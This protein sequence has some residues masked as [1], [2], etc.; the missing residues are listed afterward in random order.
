LFAGVILISCAVTGFVATLGAA[1]LW[2]AAAVARVYAVADPYRY[3]YADSPV[4][5]AAAASPLAG[6]FTDEVLYWTPLIQAW[7]TVYQI[8]PNLIATLIQIESCGDPAVSSPAGAQ[9]LFQVMPF[10]FDPG[11]D[12]LDVSTNA[13]RGME[14][15]AGSLEIADGHAGLALAGYNGGHGVIHRGW[16]SWAAETRRYYYW[17]ARIYAEAVAGLAS[18]STLDEWLA[19]GGSHLCVQARQT[20]SELEAAQ[21]VQVIVVPAN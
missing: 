20:Q 13:R 9:G 18:S 2:N 3:G 17:G 4:G 5:P 16:A 15:L 8:D 21:R 1:F 10:H 7:A 19:A 14:Y 11:E 6:V 12:M